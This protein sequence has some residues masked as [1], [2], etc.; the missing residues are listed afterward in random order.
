MRSIRGVPRSHKDGRSRVAKPL[1]LDCRSIRSV[2]R[3]HKDGSNR[4]TSTFLPI[5]AFSHQCNLV[6]VDCIEMRILGAVAGH[7]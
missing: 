4:V 2:P 7:A 1:G 3:G 5:S 6:G